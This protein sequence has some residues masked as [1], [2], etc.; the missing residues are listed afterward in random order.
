MFAFVR[1][2][3]T[4]LDL[5]QRDFIVIFQRE[6]VSKERGYQYM[7]FVLEDVYE[8]VADAVETVGCVADADEKLEDVPP[9]WVMLC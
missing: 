2:V 8:C 6:R 1:L 9:E 7:A 4:A 5:P 3:Y